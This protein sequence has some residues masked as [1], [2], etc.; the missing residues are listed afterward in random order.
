MSAFMLKA[1]HG[2]NY[3]PPNAVGMFKDVPVSHWAAR[4]VEQAA[5]E[6]LIPA[7]NVSLKLFCPTSPV[8]RDYIAVFLLKAKYGT[9]YTPPQPVGVF[10]DVTVY[11]WAAPWVEKLA[12]DGVTYGCTTTPRKYCPT[13]TVTREQM[14]VFL[15]KNFNIP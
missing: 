13:M 15:V 3:L 12:A 9:S 10:T 11:N 5:Q 4:W 1:K 8:T 14:S 6:G 7:C 2:A